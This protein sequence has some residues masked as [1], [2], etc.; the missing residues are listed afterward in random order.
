M[1]KLFVSYN[2]RTGY[3]DD[4]EYAYQKVENTK[5][6]IDFD[7]LTVDY[8]IDNNIEVL[9]EDGLPKEWFFT[10]KGLNIVTIIFGEWRKYHEYSDIVIDFLS[11][12]DKRYFMGKD[13]S[14]C[15]NDNF[16]IDRIVNLISKM[17]WDSDFF[18]Y[19]IAYL[20][21]MHLTENIMY[22]IERF[23]RKENIR[24][25]EYLCNCHDRKSVRIAEENGFSF[26][27]IRLT[28]KRILDGV[29]RTALNGLVF[30]KATEKEIPRLRSMCRDFY[31]DSRYYFDSNFGVERIQEFYQNWVEKGVRGKFDHECYCLFENNAPVAFCTLRYHEEKSVNIGLFGVD[32]NHQ[33]R[34]LGKTMI[35]SI[36]N[37]LYT[38]NILRVF[39]V[40]QGRNYDAQRL[41][42]SAGFRTHSTQLWYHKWM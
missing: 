41:Y 8:L 4:L 20:S 2:N 25:I 6:R 23:I 5:A 27:D 19:N 34:H 13:C 3:G 42:Q 28:Y 18:G 14:V 11:H 22:Q 38:R 36:F 10:L 32:L 31:K 39:V 26:T 37:Y 24:L 35:G 30:K 16:H 1:K 9:I 7:S 40:T 33:G 15:K 12:N 17:E 21:C 29:E